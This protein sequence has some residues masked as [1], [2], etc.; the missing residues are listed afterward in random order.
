MIFSIY[1]KRFDLECQFKIFYIKKALVKC[2]NNIENYF[3]ILKI[4]L[5][6]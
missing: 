3:L 4:D 5:D 6:Y 2:V 1:C